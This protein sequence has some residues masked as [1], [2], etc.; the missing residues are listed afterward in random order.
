MAKKK[1]Y[2]FDYASS[3][4]LDKRVFAVMKPIF[5]DDYG[6]PSNLYSLGR[7]TK[8]ILETSTKKITSVMGCKPSEF[9][10]TASA[11][12]SD[13]LAII[14][15]VRANKE[16]GNK[17][18][19]SNVEHKSVLA[20]AEALEKEGFEIQ[21]I[22]ISKDGL[23]DTE[24]LAKMLDDKTVLVSITYSD[25]E[26]GTIQPIK[27]IGKMIKE[28]RL[29]N[30]SP[31]PYLH[32]DAAQAANFLDI[33]VNNLGVDLMTL[34]AQ[35][36]YGPKGIGGLYIRLGTAIQP[37]I[38]GGGQ[39]NNIRSGTENI[40]GI[41]G[42]GEAMSLIKKENHK[43]YMRIARLRDKLEA[44][45]L[46]KIERVIVNGN[47]VHR[48]P[49]FLNVSILDIEGEAALLYLDNKGILINTG[50][51]CNSQTLEPSYVLTAFGR[52][53]E[54]VHGSLRF[55]L[56]KYTTEK[57]IDY[58]LKVLPPLIKKLREISPLNL[59]LGD[60]KETSLPTAFVGNQLP[61]FLREKYE[62]KEKEI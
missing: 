60:E 1:T 35:K 59:Q 45:I 9:I 37:I 30:N 33:N 54:Y 4:P 32:T 18:I 47:P 34:S 19:I 13:N 38:Y 29:K 26:T 62:K 3:T 10:F 49:N 58:V 50:S 16:K 14:G 48:L 25:S 24:E 40:A 12:E 53:Y 56:G 15:T 20:A 52:P 17:I 2:Y 11:T 41:A 22:K 6:N 7:Q 61:H 23:V 8:S 44:G 21:K 36:I 42:F 27:K 46:K 51:A 57:E 31:L 5:T 28:F 39:Q 55:T 43:E